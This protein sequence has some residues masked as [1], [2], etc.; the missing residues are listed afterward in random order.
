VDDHN[1][2]KVSNTMAATISAES[3]GKLVSILQDK[4]SDSIRLTPAQFE[5]IKNDLPDRSK[6]IVV[7]MK[8]PP[9]RE[10]IA[11]LPPE[12]ELPDAPSELELEAMAL[13]LELELL[14]F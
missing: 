10:R 1:F 14:E 6:R 9:P 3:I 7:N 2:A 11:P 8:L 13:E 5:T 4:F 12:I